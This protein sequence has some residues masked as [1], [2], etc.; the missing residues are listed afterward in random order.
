MIE[1]LDV[2]PGVRYKVTDFKNKL[3]AHECKNVFTKKSLKVEK[4]EMNKME[5]DIPDSGP[6]PECSYEIGPNIDSL[7]LGETN[8]ENAKRR[9]GNLDAVMETTVKTEDVKI[10]ARNGNSN[11]CLIHSSLVGT[12]SADLMIKD[13]FNPSTTVG[14]NI[15]NARMKH[16]K[17]KVR[18]SGARVALESLNVDVGGKA[19]DFVKKV[20]TS[21]SE[22]CVMND[23]LTSNKEVK[24][25]N[26]EIT[27]SMSTADEQTVMPQFE[28]IACV[29]ECVNVKTDNKWEPHLTF[30]NK[31]E[32]KQLVQ[33]RKYTFLDM[34]FKC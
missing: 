18:S 7:T 28:E 20:E 14:R 3:K 30:A 33:E 27:V 16:Q 23:S 32:E 5:K 11:E 34:G 25:K 2:F 21:E 1:K 31:S 26:E 8:N 15:L 10:L 12:E 6:V 4:Q 29:E 19:T 9:N 13:N 24:V 17:C 22:D